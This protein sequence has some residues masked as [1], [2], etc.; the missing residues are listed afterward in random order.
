MISDP[1]LTLTEVCAVTRL[2]RTTIWK[3]SQ[4]GDFPTPLR[5]A[6]RKLAWRR[7]SIEAWLDRGAVQ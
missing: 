4:I 3:Y 6:G 5:L 2:H 1:I 7:S